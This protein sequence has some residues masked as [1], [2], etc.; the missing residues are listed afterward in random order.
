MLSAASDKKILVRMLLRSMDV[1][2]KK[3]CPL[4]CFAFLYCIVV[5]FCMAPFEAAAASST[6]RAVSFA[7]DGSFEKVTIE[8][9]RPAAYKANFLDHNPQANIPYRLYFD[10]ANTTFERGV[11]RHLSVQG[12]CVR[13][14]RSALNDLHTVRVVLEV[15][16]KRLRRRLYGHSA[17]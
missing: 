17:Q 7:V 10:L 2:R 15:N 8:L 4:A 12:D 6:V 1:L 13:V 14:V 3:L 16:H 11:N 5:G 9:S